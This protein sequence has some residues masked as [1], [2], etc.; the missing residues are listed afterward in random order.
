MKKNV[1]IAEDEE[2]FVELMEDFIGQRDED[3]PG[4]EYEVESTTCIREAEQKILS[5]K[6]DLVFLDN[7][8]KGQ[9]DSGMGLMKK[10]PENVKK[11][12]KIAM[13]TG[14]HNLELLQEF[15]ELG[16]VNYVKKG[17]LN[18]VKNLEK[19]LELIEEEIPKPEKP[20]LYVLHAASGTGKS[21]TIKHITN[22]VPYTKEIKKYATGIY[23]EDNENFPDILLLKEEI[24]KPDWIVY[25]REKE[26]V[27]VNPRDI[28]EGLEGGYDCFFATGNPAQARALQVM[29]PS[30]TLGM[31]IHPEDDNDWKRLLRKRPAA[32]TR[33]FT[34]RQEIR[35]R[36]LHRKHKLKYDRVIMNEDFFNLPLEIREHIK[37][38]RKY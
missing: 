4:I 37:N 14:H 18:M 25:E 15:I 38:K 8:F 5:E 30:Y 24:I 34:Y 19:T 1:L 33:T 3:T 2:I 13:I 16:G 17:N 6:Y 9:E 7:N 31:Y 22:N 21:E 32:D 29:F 35:D 10:L 27:A 20:L 28:K 23:G 26:K 12:T 36:I 11:Q